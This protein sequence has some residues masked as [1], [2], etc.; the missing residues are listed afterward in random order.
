MGKP[1]GKVNYAAV[2]RHHRELC[3]LEALEK[4]PTL[5]EDGAIVF[6]SGRLKPDGTFNGPIRL[7]EF[8]LE[9]TGEKKS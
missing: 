1:K 8:L 9:L 4:W 7:F 2:L 5:R 3:P 6:P